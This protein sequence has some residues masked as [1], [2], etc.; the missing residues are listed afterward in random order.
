MGKL[1]SI[2][3]NNRNPGWS[4]EEIEKHYTEYLGVTNFI[5]LNGTK[6]ADITDDHIDGTARFADD[7]TIVTISENDTWSKQ[8]FRILSKAEIKM[9]RHTKLLKSR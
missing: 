2:A 4:I 6:G 1:S 5:W 3:N 8:E 9:V 7:N